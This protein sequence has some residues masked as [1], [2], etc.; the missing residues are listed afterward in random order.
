[1]VA[2]GEQSQVIMTGKKIALPLF[3]N[4]VT[5]KMSMKEYFGIWNFD[6]WG[7]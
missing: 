3:G 2:D 6:W 1:M 7:E 5:Y 4:D